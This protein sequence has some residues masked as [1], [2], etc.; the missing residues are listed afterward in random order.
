MGLS[1]SRLSSFNDKQSNT[2]DVIKQRNEE[3]VRFER[4]TKLILVRLRK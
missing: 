3:N 4:S 1:D 2:Y